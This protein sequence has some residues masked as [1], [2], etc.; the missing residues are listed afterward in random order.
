V[1][2]GIGAGM[3]VAGMGLVRLDLRD[4]Y[5]QAMTSGYTSTLEIQLGL[6]RTFG[7]SSAA[8]VSPP[9]TEEA[10]VSVV[11]DPPVAKEKDTDGDGVPDSIDKCPFEPQTGH[12][13]DGCPE[14]DS[15][16]DGIPDSKDQCPNE[17][18]DFDH[19]Q[20]EDGCPDLDNDND[21]IPDSADAC[22]ND[23][24]TYNGYRDD[25]GCPDEVP[26]DV[27]HA[28]SGAAGV[29]FEAGKPKLV[30]DSRVA[31]KPL[32]DVLQKIP[33]LRVVI[34]GHPDKAGDAAENLARKRA[35]AVRFYLEDQG[36]PVVRDEIAA[37]DVVAKGAATVDFALV[38]VKPKPIVSPG[39]NHNATGASPH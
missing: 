2:A 20:D 23:P 7:G 26:D 32:I 9:P 17:P 28:L 19:F 37:G 16:G 30:K 36:I 11:D 24:E 12:G 29:K 22:P 8:S 1:Y 33:T 31:L 13:V 27:K 6:T 5:M 4:A 15:D 25:D 3:R 10:P 34:T 39:P 21:G 38:I 18:E 14:K 35:E